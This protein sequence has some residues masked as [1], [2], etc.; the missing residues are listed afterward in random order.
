MSY[1]PA[2][3]FSA[4]WRNIA[5]VVSKVEMPTLDL[6]V[7]ALARANLITLVASAMAPVAN[8]STTAWLDTQTP[9]WAGEGT[10]NLWNPATTAYVAAT[11][12]L[13]VIMLQTAAGQNGVS[14][15]TSAGGPPSN[16]VGNNGDFAIRTDEPH[17]IYGPKAAGAWPANPIPGTTDTITSLALENTFG[18]AEGALIYRGPA[19]WSALEIGTPLDVLISAGGIPAWDG[20]SAL[21]DVLFSAAQGSI[22]YRDAG[23]WQAIA[24][25]AINQVLTTQGAGA[26][27][28]WT[29]KSS[30]FTS[31][32]TMI[33]QQSSAPTGWTKQ[34]TLNDC[35]LRVVS[36]AVGT[37]G[38]S[39]FSTVFAQ[40]AVGSTTE[41]I[42]TMP[43]HTHPT[44]A[45]I[46]NNAFGVGTG[47][48][49]VPNNIGATNDSTGGGGSHTHSVNLT[50]A[51]TDVIIATKN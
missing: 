17:G 37:T 36:G 35:G 43:N 46:Y 34:T 2:T 23:A 19:V 38:G 15:W 10:L 45:M 13:F 42:A 6:V 16:T 9:S 3:D 18:T 47:A 50:L 4:L 31:G 40:S 30:E 20:L 41:T 14:W 1:N 25:G 48:V 7:S 39:A 51:Y 28:T 27:P 33:F 26:D 22:L 21:F 5:G 44:N 29:A 24:P 12:A 11:P 49:D 8:Q 32:T